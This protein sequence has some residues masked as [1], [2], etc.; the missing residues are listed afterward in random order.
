MGWEELEEVLEQLWEELA[1]AGMGQ[2]AIEELQR[3][4]QA[5]QEALSEQVGQYAGMSIARRMTKQPPR[6]NGPELMHRPFRD[7]SQAEA[8]ELRSQVRRLAARLRS[9]AALR[10]KRANSGFLDAK[11][12][13]RANQR[14]GGVPLDLHYKHRHLKPKLA[15]ICDVS[16]S[17]RHCA[18]FMLR[19]IYELQDQVAKA[20]SFAFISDIEE[21]SQ[22]F[23]DNQ[24]EVAV[25]QVLT[26]MPAGFYNTNLGYSL[27]TFCHD[28]LDAV[29]RRTTV[30][31]LGDGRN[32]F[33]DPRLDL[34]QSIRRRARR[35]IWLNPE[36]APLWGTGD[37]DALEYLPLCDAIYE[38][39][40][41]AQL[42][43]AVDRLLT[44]R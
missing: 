6:R 20:R 12:T 15:L 39:G 9:R 1:Q 33:N 21:I 26:R 10:Q 13:I 22:D 43:E 31:L 44:S 14:Y 38:V 36:S 29:D 4:I 24:P 23:A 32:N 7:L 35:I 37:S 28:Y 30:I 16:T 8:D 27:D 2:E 42:T 18:E 17:V 11:R 34:L 5:N 25:D 40:N 19:L 3:M 41:L